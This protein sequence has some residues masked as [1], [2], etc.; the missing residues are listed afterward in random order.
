[1]RN[2][3]KILCLVTMT[4]F[5]LTILQ[6]ATHFIKVKPLRGAYVSAE[7]PQF[8]FPTFVVGDW[9]QQVDRYIKDHHGFREPAIRLYNQYL[10]TAYRRST[11]PGSVVIGKDNYLFEPWFVDEYYTGCF[12]HFYPD[13]LAI[14]D[15]EKGYVFYNRMS[16]LAKLQ[17]I[18]E[19]QG[20]HLFLALLPGKE[21]IYPQYLP[22]RGAEAQGD[23]LCGHHRAYDFYRNS[24][25]GFR[26]VDICH[27]F[28]S[29]RGNTPYLLFTKTGTHWSSIASTYA[30]DSIMRYM[31]T[32][33]PI[34]RPVT[35]GKPYY[36][37]TREPDADL[38]ELLNKTFHIPTQR[39]QY[40]DVAL[41]DPAPERNPSLV[42]IGD[43]F[44]WNILYNF[45]IQ[46]LFSDFRYWYYFSTIYYDPDHD[47]V[48][49]ID[50]V[51]ELLRTDYVMLSY[52]TV[53][54][55]NCGNGFINRALLELC[56]DPEEIQAVRDSLAADTTS[57]LSVDQRIDRYLEQYFPALAE[58]FPTKRS[59]RLNR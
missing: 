36:A 14:P 47:N 55:Y 52:C 30:F 31:Q 41:G 5:L 7:K 9:Q 48:A 18:L 3:P 37:R 27:C 49:D 57:R 59:S 54:L 1:M 24:H 23:R 43:S 21:R 53:Q 17:A 29:L 35:L 11:N 40:V 12:S 26:C 45:P 46:E 50:L 8:T 6:G 2:T 58:P 25:Y 13:S 39:N 22:D 38:D 51:D 42:V 4:L 15:Y 20:V 32:F 56:Y 16:R 28:D 34:I 19:E 44:F 10:W 33:G